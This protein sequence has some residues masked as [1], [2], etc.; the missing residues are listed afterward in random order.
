[1]DLFKRVVSYGDLHHNFKMIEKDKSIVTVINE[2]AEGFEDRDNK[3]V[4]E[5]QTT[6]NS[7][8]W[9]LY[10]HA[11]L[12]SLE[13]KVDFSYNRPDFCSCKNEQS[14]IIEAVITNNPANGSPEYDRQKALEEFYKLEPSQIEGAYNEVKNLAAERILNSITQK[15]KLYCNNYQKLDHVQNKPFVIAIGAF[16]QP[17]FYYQAA[18]GIMKALFGLESA[19]Y[20]NGEGVFEYKDKLLKKSNGAEIPIG[21]F[22]DDRMKEISA[23]I[24]CPIATIGKIRALAEKKKK[25]CFVTTQRYNDYGEK[26]DIELLKLSEHQESLQDG[27]QIYMNPFAENKIDKELFYHDDF[28]I[29]Y[30]K[31]DVSMKHGFLYARMLETFELKKD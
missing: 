14:I 26:S 29:N 3:F 25:N 7:S 23:V 19:K 16:E 30:S 10:L 31:D 9:E 22:S 6:F 5:F 2:W 15:H 20:V 27:V 21:L 17:L 4:K 8:F 28:L 18:G 13:F 11:L 24:F 1:M 12:K